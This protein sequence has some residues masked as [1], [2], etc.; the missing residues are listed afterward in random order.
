MPLR[1]YEESLIQLLTKLDAVESDG[2]DTVKKTRKMVVAAVEHEL[3]ELDGIKKRLGEQRDKSSETGEL[4]EDHMELDVK[5]EEY[6]GSSTGRHEDD[7]SDRADDATSEPTTD[8]IEGTSLAVEPSSPSTESVT[9]TSS[10]APDDSPATPVSP[11]A[12]LPPDSSPEAKRRSYATTIEE[13]P[14]ESEGKKEWGEDSEYVL[15]EDV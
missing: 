13:V 9:T 7:I 2:S 14:D 12:T 6:G 1:A 5:K 8:I 4:G 11:A 3:A 15:V 10:D